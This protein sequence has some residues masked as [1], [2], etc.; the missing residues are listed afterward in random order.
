MGL[1]YRLRQFWRLVQDEPF[2]QEQW[3]LVEAILT[4]A[5]A[6]L[7]KQQ[8]A[9]DQVHGLRVLQTL[10]QAGETDACLL[11]AA[12]LHD[13]GKCRLRPTLW[14]RVSGAILE[15]LFPA[16]AARWGAAELTWWRRP[17]IIRR[18]H[19]AWGAD[20][21]REA[22]SA[23]LTVQLIGHH[24]DSLDGLSDDEQR[25]LLA[26]LQWADDQN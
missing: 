17:L 7:F 2:P 1:G 18:Q 11:A 16:R 24:Q 6:A 15:K 25:R 14:D 13:V 21:A 20:M 22:G 9:A 4:P 10:R 8:A 19:A 23:P 3:P 5:E 26:R 12:L